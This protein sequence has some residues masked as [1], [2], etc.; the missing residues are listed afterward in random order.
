M[1]K[2]KTKEWN[3]KLHSFFK[4]IWDEREDPSGNCYCYETNQLLEGYKYRNNSLCYHHIL[5]KYKYPQFAF[6]PWNIV[7]LHPDVHSQVETNIDKCPKT[8]SLTQ[9]IKNDRNS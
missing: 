6:E 2:K 7:I 3:S 4:K 5:P 8:K 9:K 1:K